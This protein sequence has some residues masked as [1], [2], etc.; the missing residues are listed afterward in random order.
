[1]NARSGDCAVPRGRSISSEAKLQGLARLS[2]V[3]PGG[4][5][6]GYLSSLFWEQPEGHQKVVPTVGE[7]VAKKLLLD[8]SWCPFLE[9][10]QEGNERNMTW[11]PRPR[12]P[13]RSREK[14]RARPGDEPPPGRLLLPLPFPHYRENG[15]RFSATSLCGSRP[16]SSTTSS[17]TTWAGQEQKSFL[18]S[19]GGLKG[20]HD[21][22][23][24]P[25]KIPSP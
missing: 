9:R 6:L 18:I 25:I 19:T 11:P 17:S 8:F 23:A 16:S 4:D 1:M 5:I 10:F 13:G 21:V 3:W 22:A 14:P 2:A 24:A 15:L 20:V 12:Q 7:K